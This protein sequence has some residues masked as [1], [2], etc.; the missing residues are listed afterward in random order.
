[1]GNVA[2]NHSTALNEVGEEPKPHLHTKT[3]LAVAAVFGIY[4]AQVYCLVGAG[5]VSV[6]VEFP[7]VSPLLMLTGPHSKARRSRPSSMPRPS[8]HGSPGRWPSSPSCSGQ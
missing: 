8:R 1:M 6:T 4:F 5:A 2:S 7:T 3:F